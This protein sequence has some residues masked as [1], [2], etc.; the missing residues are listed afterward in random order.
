MND[1]NYSKIFYKSS[2]IKLSDES[3]FNSYRVLNREEPIEN[4]LNDNEKIY[5]ILKL[6]GD[7][8]NRLDEIYIFSQK[9]IKKIGSDRLKSIFD[10]HKDLNDQRIFYY[11]IFGEEPKYNANN[12][13]SI[14]LFQKLNFCYVANKYQYDLVIETFNKMVLPLYPNN[15]FLQMNPRHVIEGLINQD[16]IFWLEY[17]NNDYYHRLEN[18]IRDYIV[19]DDFNKDAI[20]LPYKYAS[21]YLYAIS[22]IKSKDFELKLVNGNNFTICYNLFKKGIKCFKD[23]VLDA[24]DFFEIIDKDFFVYN[25]INF[26][27]NDDRIKEKCLDCICDYLL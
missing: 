4:Y 3:G 7:Y 18:Y 26:F 11:G 20:T 14:L 2:I 22:N 9:L 16:V 1:I 17:G 12:P 10:S 8:S 6:A 21:V 27:T 25:Q 19:E 24:E 13:K 23:G 15:I 5:E